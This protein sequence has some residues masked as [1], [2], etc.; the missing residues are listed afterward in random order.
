MNNAIEGL[1]Q[2]LSNQGNA[3]VAPEARE[4]FHQVVHSTP[5]EVLSQ[6]LNE[7]F[8]SDQTPPFAQMVGHLFGHADDQ[9]KAGIVS[10]LLGSLGG[11]THPALAQAGINATPEQATQLSTDQV[12]QIA[13]QAQQVN[14]GIV[15]Q[16]SNFYAQHPTLVKSLGAAAMAIVLGRMHSPRR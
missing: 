12:Q 13:S 4:Q 14:P 3:P 1:L 8:N 16:M 10:T 15:G 2:Q 5:P 11:G 9:Q 7:A 6:G